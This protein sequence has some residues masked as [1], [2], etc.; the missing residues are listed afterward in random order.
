MEK[1]I[2]EYIAQSEKW[3]SEIFTSRS[4][5]NPDTIIKTIKNFD[6]VSELNVEWNNVVSNSR[7]ATIYQTFEWQYNWWNYF[8]SGK[9]NSLHILMILSYGRLIGI[10]PFY[11]HE[12]SFGGFI[13][14]RQLRLIG[15]GLNSEISLSNAIEER[16][17][18]DYLDIIAFEGYERKVADEI[19]SYL[20]E[21]KF[22]F[23]EIAFQNVSEESFIFRWF[24][25]KLWVKNFRVR[26]NKTDTCP[27]LRVPHS[28]DI[29]LS[30]LKAGTRRKCRQIRKQT[31]ENAGIEIIN[32][33]T[34]NFLN[35]VQ[36]LKRLHQNRW[37]ERGHLGLFSDKRF[38]EF[39][40]H[41]GKIFLD[42]GWLWF[43][44]V[45]LDSKIVGSR[46]AY[47]FKDRI[48][49]YL[50][51][52]DSEQG[53]ASM[54]PGITLIFSM[55]ED[56]VL[57]NYKTVDFLRG[58]E[59]Y[60]YEFSSGECCNYSISILSPL[61]TS[62]FRTI[63]FYFVNARIKLW[64]RIKTE[65]AMIKLQVKR[66]GKIMF[67][68]P[69]LKFCLGRLKSFVVKN[70]EKNFKEEEIRQPHLEDDLIKRD[71]EK[72]KNYISRRV[73]KTAAHSQQPLENETAA[74]NTKAAE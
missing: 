74:V 36:T 61:S 57:L 25:H 24:L 46:M 17:I 21:F 60:K 33:D 26:I 41:I 73:K 3:H 51:G 22:F 42:K 58:A 55:I 47:K 38:E 5:K 31:E 34:A 64:F 37:N 14:Y 1:T 27:R 13:I 68:I 15:S 40:Q 6:A 9:H 8:A 12:Y 45:K 53:T 4:A 48:Y 32:V 28:M 52:F 72:N 19:I 65:T 66:H 50:S 30:Y 39:V 62:V 35:S 49:D 69:Y 56:A 63:L 59:E 71:A 7:Q 11:I 20:N 29:Y 54:R 67:L 18:S 16:G 44:E 10:A 43:K 23:D 2:Y 70:E